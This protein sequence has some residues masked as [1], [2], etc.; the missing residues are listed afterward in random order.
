MKPIIV[1][2]GQR[3]GRLILIREVERAASGRRRF[4]FLCDCGGIIVTD[5]S[6]VKAGKTS[7][8]GCYRKENTSQAF[9][10]HGDTRSPEHRTWVHINQR[11][12]NEED[13]DYKYYGGRGITVCERWRFSFE[14]FLT[15]MKR[16]PSPKHTLDRRDNDGPYSPDNCRWATRLMQSRN[17]RRTIMIDYKGDRMTLIEASQ[18]E[19]LKYS[20][21]LQRYHCG[22]VG[23][24]LFRPVK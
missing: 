3:F 12:R 13:P 7:S 5:M 23:E 2:P 20:T 8:C 24:V 6:W 4:E 18:K 1:T 21:V 17:Q 11:C 10:T 15:D 19:G 9:T 14:N 22:D 16:R